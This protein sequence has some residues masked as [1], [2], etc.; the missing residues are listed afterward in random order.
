[1]HPEHEKINVDDVI[2]SGLSDADLKV[3]V[4]I[5]VENMSPNGFS[6]LEM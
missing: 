1:M 3:L 2:M 5:V 4:D 6:A